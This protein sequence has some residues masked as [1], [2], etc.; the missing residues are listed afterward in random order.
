MAID[1]TWRRQCTVVDISDEGA[2]LAA[3]NIG[4]LQM[5]EFFLLLTSVGVAYRR[6]KL[7]WVNGEQLG[8]T[9]ISRRLAKKAAQ[10]NRDEEFVK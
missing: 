10:R 4:K 5:T 9:F 1:G 7:A 3:S 8:V 6:C 2:Q